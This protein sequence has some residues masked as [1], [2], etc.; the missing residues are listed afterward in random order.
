MT[1]QRQLEL[2]RRHP[3]TVVDDA[4]ELDAPLLHRNVNSPRARVERILD[5]LLDDGCRPL[6]DLA[7]RD[8]VDELGR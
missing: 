3:A 7:G 8:L 4:N 2:L 5:E 6:D 1:G